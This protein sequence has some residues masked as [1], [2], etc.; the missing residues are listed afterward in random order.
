[1]KRYAVAVDGAPLPGGTYEQ[2]ITVRFKSGGN[3][4]FVVNEVVDA[5]GRP[6]RPEEEDWLDLLKA[7]HVAD[8]VCH[9]GENEDW[10][11]SITLALP[12]RA[13]DRFSLWVPLIQEIGSPGTAVMGHT[14]W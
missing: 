3:V 13:P 8:L 2:T 7:I 5:I 9:R 6:L 1:M 10:D 4:N 14:V 12:L 11:R